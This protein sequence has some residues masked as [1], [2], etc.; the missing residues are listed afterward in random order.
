MLV[1]WHDIDPNGEIAGHGPIAD[2]LDDVDAT[3][4]KRRDDIKIQANTGF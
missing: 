3:V 1:P 4:L 2:L